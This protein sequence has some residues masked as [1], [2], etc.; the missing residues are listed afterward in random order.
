MSTVNRHSG[1]KSS[2]GQHCRLG[3]ALRSVRKT[4]R[5]SLDQLSVMAGVSK[6]MLSQ[7]ERD[8]ANP[9]VAVMLKI[10][11]ALRV[12]L[13]ELLDD[14]QSHNVIRLIPHTDELYTFR[15]DDACNIRTLSPLELEKTIEFYRVSLAPAGQLHSEGHF[16]GTEEIIHLAKGKL[17]VTSGGQT[18]EIVKGDSIH[19]RSDVPHCLSNKGKGRAE[20]YMIVRYRQD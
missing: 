20:V 2:A 1:K 15:S 12:S 16:A 14:R 18:V 8:K 11:R 3:R 10:S 6:A 13:S 5:L 7:I 19:Y 9:T 4:R 17:E